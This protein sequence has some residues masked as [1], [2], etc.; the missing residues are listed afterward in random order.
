MRSEGDALVIL[1][2]NVGNVEADLPQHLDKVGQ[3]VVVQDLLVQLVELDL[4]VAGEGLAFLVGEDLLKGLRDHTLNPDRNVL[5]HEVLYH[6]EVICMVLG[7]ELDLVE[8]LMDLFGVNLVIHSVD[9]A[10][11]QGLCPL[12]Q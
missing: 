4:L 8:L 11:R 6:G 2:V 7:L 5:L 1:E 12:E 9:L 3:P 10:V